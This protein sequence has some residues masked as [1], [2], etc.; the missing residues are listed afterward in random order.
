M[1]EDRVTQLSAALRRVI[2]DSSEWP[3]DATGGEWWTEAVAPPARIRTLGIRLRSDD[4]VDV[5]LEVDVFGR[6]LEVFEFHYPIHDDA[7][8]DRFGDVASFVDEL[9]TERTALGYARG[10][11]RGGR[12]LV[13]PATLTDADRQ[14]LLWIV[15]WRGTHDWQADDRP[16]GRD[17]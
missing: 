12:E 13:E 7:V 9:M 1:P 4:D 5:V 8:D 15:S 10:W 6:S 14:R 17:R 2:P 11:L 3:R 16:A